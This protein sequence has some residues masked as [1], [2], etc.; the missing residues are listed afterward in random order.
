M[1]KCKKYNRYACGYICVHTHLRELCVPHPLG[2]RVEV[3]E[4]MWI[5]TIVYN[6]YVCVLMCTYTPV[7]TPCTPPHRAACWGRRRNVN[8]QNRYMCAYIYVHAHLGKLRV[9][10]PLGQRVEVD[11]ECHESARAG[12]SLPRGGGGQVS[13]SY[14]LSVSLDL[15]IH[16]NIYIHT[17]T[18]THARTHIHI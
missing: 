5:Y 6:R 2:Q 14:S 17:H 4:D 16:I 11:K 1:N 3:D 15:P 9:P 18:R 13:I 7:G 10:H 8:T 12:A